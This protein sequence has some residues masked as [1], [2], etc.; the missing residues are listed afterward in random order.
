MKDS[1]TQLLL[2][3]KSGA[4]VTQYLEKENIFSVKEKK[5]REG[6]Y[7]EKE[8]IWCGKISG[9]WRR[10]RADR[11]KEEN[12]WSRKIF[13]QCAPRTPHSP[14]LLKSCTLIVPRCSEIFITA[15]NIIKS[16]DMELCC[17]EMMK[18]PKMAIIMSMLIIVVMVIT[19]TIMIR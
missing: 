18:I 13:G 7:L 3:Y 6:K 2:K 19:M 11:E 14:P 10:R 9:Q 8:N 4:I 17:D 12:I 16:V 5:N 15:H 1:A